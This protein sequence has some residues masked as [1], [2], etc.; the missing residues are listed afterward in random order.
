MSI[1]CSLLWHPP[2]CHPVLEPRSFARYGEACHY[3]GPCREDHQ[4]LLPLPPVAARLTSR[5]LVHVWK[6]K[7]HSKIVSKGVQPSVE[8]ITGWEPCPDAKGLRSAQLVRGHGA[9]NPLAG[10]KIFCH[11]GEGKKIFFIYILQMIPW[12]PPGENP[13]RLDCWGLPTARHRGGIG[14]YILPR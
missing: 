5:V 14:T 2:S 1:P 11:R 3:A 9:A 12:E 6:T 13:L 10:E 8:N 4:K 7:N